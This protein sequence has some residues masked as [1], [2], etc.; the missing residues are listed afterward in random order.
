M[1]AYQEEV[2]EAV[3]GSFKVLESL[4]ANGKKCH[5]HIQNTHHQLI[6]RLQ[7]LKLRQTSPDSTASVT[8]TV[9]KVS[10][11][12]E[13]LYARSRSEG[14]GDEVK[15]RILFGTYALSADHHEDLYVKAQKVRTLIAQDFASVF[16]KYD[17]II[18]PITC[19][20]C[21]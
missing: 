1:K 11:N 12:L 4:G 17:V 2:K 21:I 8:V 20:N 6:M 15:K 18:G 9:L 3:R 5:F 10:K 14:F 13:E 7:H 19:D 16:E